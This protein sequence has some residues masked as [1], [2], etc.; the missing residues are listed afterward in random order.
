[1]KT[2]KYDLSSFSDGYFFNDFEDEQDFF[3]QKNIGGLLIFIHGKKMIWLCE[4]PGIR[5]W[6]KKTFK[7]DIWNGC[8]IASL[9]NY[10]DPLVKALPGVIIHP[11][12]TDSVYLPRNIEN[13]EELMQKLIELIHK[14][15]PLIG[16]EIEPSS[17]S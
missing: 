3:Y 13:Y 2:K 6:R 5:R 4:K 7:I 15:S 1:M 16:V 12:I 17:L 9:P 8:L 14:R 11:V 10:H